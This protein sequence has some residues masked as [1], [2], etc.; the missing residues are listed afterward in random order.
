MFKAEAARR[1]ELKE[2]GQNSTEHPTAIS[3]IPG[4]Q[5]R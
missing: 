1:R 2:Q 3:I 4:T 5:E